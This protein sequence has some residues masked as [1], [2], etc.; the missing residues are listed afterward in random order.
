MKNIPM[1]HPAHG[2]S[3]GQSTIINGVVVGVGEPNPS[4]IFISDVDKKTSEKLSLILNKLD[5]AVDLPEGEVIN[6]KVK[7]S[8]IISQYY[9]KHLNRIEKNKLIRLYENSVKSSYSA[10]KEFHKKVKDYKE[11]RAIFVSYSVNFII[12]E[13]DIF[14]GN[15][16]AIN[17]RYPNLRKGYKLP[18]NSIRRELT[19][20]IESFFSGEY[21]QNDKKVQD[22]EE[23]IIES[24]EN[25][26]ISKLF[27]ASTMFD[28]SMERDWYRPSLPR[29]VPKTYS[30]FEVVNEETLGWEARIYTAEHPTP[31]DHPALAEV[32]RALGAVHVSIIAGIWRIVKKRV[33]KKTISLV[34]FEVLEETKLTLHADEFERW[35]VANGSASWIHS[36]DKLLLKYRRVFNT[37]QDSKKWLDSLSP[38]NNGKYFPIRSCSYSVGSYGVHWVCHQNSNAF[39]LRKWNFIPVNYPLTYTIF[40]IYGTFPNLQISR[41]KDPLLKI[42]PIHGG[43]PGEGLHYNT[44]PPY[45]PDPLQLF[46]HGKGYGLDEHWNPRKNDWVRSNNRYLEREIPIRGRSVHYNHTDGWD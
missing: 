39:S 20:A 16:K 27:E 43:V 38:T 36:D 22:I 44:I 9:G 14:R 35:I 26:Q 31:I 46:Y 1:W 2:L 8:R 23:K 18:D 28:A 30:I 17:H 33:L 13:M 25:S 11:T 41:K 12:S 45:G 15:D 7:Y 42:E 24:K 40:G 4:K 34:T 3:K 5:S 37:Y 10:L 19:S 32:M 29:I 6:L 21:L